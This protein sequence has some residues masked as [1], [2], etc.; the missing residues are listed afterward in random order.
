MGRK[1]RLHESADYAV[2]F[3]VDSREAE[4]A[5]LQLNC[6]PV[7]GGTYAGPGM[8]IVRAR[9]GDELALCV[10]GCG[11]CGPD[12]GCEAVTASILVL[13]LKPHCHHGDCDCDH[14]KPH[15]DCHRCGDSD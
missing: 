3:H 5:V 10:S 11:G 1:I 15:E 14:D 12:C 7:P 4:C 13:K 6:R 8:A 9:A 2:W